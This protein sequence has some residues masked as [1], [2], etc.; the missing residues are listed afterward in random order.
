MIYECALEYFR[1]S[2]NDYRQ[3]VCDM[4]VKPAVC[5]WS[6]EPPVCALGNVLVSYVV[7]S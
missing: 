3:C 5:M 2:G 1:K 7:V 6:S 4:T